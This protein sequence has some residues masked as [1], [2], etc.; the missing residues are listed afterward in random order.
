M[1]LNRKCA[2][3]QRQSISINKRFS[4]L[5]NSSALLKN[6]KAAFFKNQVQTTSIK[7]ALKTENIRRSNSKMQRAIETEF[8][9]RYA[10]RDMFLTI[11]SCNGS[12]KD[13]TT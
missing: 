13:A 9:Q 6:L 4:S 5:K 8:S 12:T 3:H 7:L 10:F 11:N 2:L 1:H